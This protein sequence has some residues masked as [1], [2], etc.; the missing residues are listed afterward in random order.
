MASYIV[1]SSH[2]TPSKVKGELPDINHQYIAI[3]SAIG[4]HYSLTNDRERAYIFEEFEL[5]DAEFIAD[6]WGMQLKKLN[7]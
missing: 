4:W 7:Y 6:C 3:D 5:K 1:R 2:L